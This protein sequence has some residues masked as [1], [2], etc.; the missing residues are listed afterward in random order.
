MVDLC[1]GGA[2][3]VSQIVLRRA[4]ELPLPFQGRSRR[5]VELDGENRDEPGAQI[6]DPTCN[7]VQPPD[8]HQAL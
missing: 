2:E 3:P 7:A 8:S 1:D 6:R 4:N 5:K